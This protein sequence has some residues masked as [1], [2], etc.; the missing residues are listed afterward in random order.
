MGTRARHLGD[1]PVLPRRTILPESLVGRPQGMA[2]ALDLRTLDAARYHHR[3]AS[4]VAARR[5]SLQECVEVPLVLEVHA[6]HERN[7]I[8]VGLQHDEWH[9]IDVLPAHRGHAGPVFARSFSRIPP[10]IP[11]VVR[12][13][14]D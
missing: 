10:L 12:P 3:S 11:P 7:A 2:S 1:V 9:R 5:P 13:T 4:A 6:W 8:T 14:S